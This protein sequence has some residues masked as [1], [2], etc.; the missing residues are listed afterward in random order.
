MALAANY[1]GLAFNKT[2]LGY[3]HAIAHQLYGAPL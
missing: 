3:V 2:A 1:G